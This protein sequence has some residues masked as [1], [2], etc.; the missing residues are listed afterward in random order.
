MTSRVN[1]AA[2][3]A[4]G[5][6]Y[7]AP[8][9][10]EG[11]AAGHLEVVRDADH[12]VRRY[13]RSSSDNEREG[14]RAEIVNQYTGFVRYLL[15]SFSNRGESDED[16]VQVA[17]V[18][19]LAAL[20]RFDPDRGPRFISFARPSILGE[21]KRYFRDKTWSVRV[22][23]SLKELS[24][25][26]VTSEGELSQELG[27][28]PTTGELAE[29]IG[30]S[31]EKVLEA[32]EIARGYKALSLDRPVDRSE[33][34]PTSLTELLGEDDTRL[35]K[36]EELAT[37]QPA[38]QQLSQYDKRLLHMRFYQGMIQSDMAAELGVSQMQI[39]RQLSRVLDHLRSHV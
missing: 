37:L 18:A 24:L 3:S 1:A 38:I 28:S 16:L 22:P 10:A 6:T 35:G 20:D 5:V 32:I 15:R 2:A 19:L 25:E 30:A 26:V 33:G 31:E 9:A 34:D 21:L 7:S 11:S 14:M 13:A 23:R 17:M 27:R 12:L 36:L 39:S 29:R 4:T 8:S